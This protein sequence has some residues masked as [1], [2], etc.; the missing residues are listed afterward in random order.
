[1]RSTKDRAPPVSTREGVRSSWA[2]S[3]SDREIR[4][5]PGTWQAKNATR[6]LAG[7]C[8]VFVRDLVPRL[9]KGTLEL[10]LWLFRHRD[11]R[12]R[13]NAAA[14]QIAR[15]L[16]KARSTVQDRLAR[17][18]ALG[19]VVLPR[20][21]SV[22][23]RRGRNGSEGLG[24]QT[25][26][27]GTRGFVRLV[28]GAEASATSGPCG[29][30]ALLLPPDVL[31]NVQKAPAN[32]HGGARRGAGGSPGNTNARGKGAVSKA[33]ERAREWVARLDEGLVLT[34]E[35]AERVDRKRRREMR[36]Q[37]AKLPPLEAAGG[38]EV[39]AG[40][41]VFEEEIRRQDRERRAARRAAPGRSS[42]ATGDGQERHPKRSSSFSSVDLDLPS[43]DAPVTST[44]VSALGSI[45]GEGRALLEFRSG[46]RGRIEAP[47]APPPL[48]GLGDRI[49]GVPPIPTRDV[50]GE[51]VMPRAPLIDP[52]AAG[53][54]LV[55]ALAVAYRA[56]VRNRFGVESHA[57]R[58]GELA[59]S[60]WFEALHRAAVILREKG[61]APIAWA[62][63]SCDVWIRYG[64]AKGKPPPIAWVYG[65]ARILER[66][67]WFSSEG[68][69][70]TEGRIVEG[71]EC[72]AMRKRY[73][74]MRWAI[75]RSR[76]ATSEEVAAIV[77]RYFPAEGP[78]SYAATV[79]RVREENRQAQ[80]QLCR[81]VQAGEYVWSEKA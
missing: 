47:V 31:Q 32:G 6:E 57:L 59:K 20:E 54:G 40:A 34:D 79:A 74:A 53:V 38:D 44:G 23:R 81:R 65:P 43:E 21:R 67:G 24:W 42:P 15:R 48:Y 64:E 61:V 50:V 49:L 9:G 4:R 25:V 35:E 52:E 22:G 58:R 5:A 12:G 69:T 66:V 14:V 51:A 39:L 16:G 45:R 70:L 36:T 68:H 1:M 30:R 71:P 17:L 76:A 8:P 75:T 7:W 19:F 80:E 28:R 63:W 46:E 62:A 3:S 78:G 60:K 13:I 26:R 77:A 11:E 2:A 73:L 72:V 33:R 18:E 29:S 27:P 10:L 41:L 37:L 55:E 56:A